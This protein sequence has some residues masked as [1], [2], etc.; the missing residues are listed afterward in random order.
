MS[1]PHP[2]LELKEIR[3]SYGT[4][5]NPVPVLHGVNLRVLEG[6]YVAIV[7]PSGSG[8]STLLNILGCLDRPTSGSY[9]LGDEDVAQMDDRQLSRIRNSRIGF[10]FQS[11]HLIS[12]LS[13]IENVEMPLF[14]ARAPK[15]ERRQYCEALLEKVGLSHRLHHLPSE[16]SGGENQRAAIA[17]ALSN[18]PALILADEP[19][20]NLD[21]KTSE[22]IMRLFY[23]LNESGVTIVMITHNLEIA[24]AAPRLVRIRD[25]LILE[26]PQPE[27]VS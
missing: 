24:R 3:K 2:T 23:E 18:T 12:H 10:V 8:K 5:K 22:D 7:G 25:G 1:T 21:S 19:T 6:Q 26:E 4:E 11:F 13:V 20:G 16:L 15:R 9:F 14:Y 17:R 27:A